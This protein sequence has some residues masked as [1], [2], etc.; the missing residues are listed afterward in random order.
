MENLNMWKPPCYEAKI[1]CSKD[2]DSMDFYSFYSLCETD[3]DFD[4]LVLRELAYNNDVEKE[5]YA[6]V[7]KNEYYLH[8]VYID[9]SYHV[10]IKEKV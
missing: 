7:F 5:P 4:A 3:E 8:N 1:Y 2:A 10:I 9:K 6:V